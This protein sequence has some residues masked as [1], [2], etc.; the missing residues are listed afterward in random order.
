MKQRKDV[1]TVRGRKGEG[2]IMVGTATDREGKGSDRK[3]MERNGKKVEGNCGRLVTPRL[4]ARHR[5]QAV[6]A[7][8]PGVPLGVCCVA[9]QYS[10]PGCPSHAAALVL[11]PLRAST[12]VSADSD[13]SAGMHLHH[14]R[15]AQGTDFHSQQVAHIRLDAGRLIRSY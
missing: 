1:T 13:S 10:C 2:K 3:E 8:V 11:A 7:G 15:G 12:A 5:P 14:P 6:S 9:L 4:R